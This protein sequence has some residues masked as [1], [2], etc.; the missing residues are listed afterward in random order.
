MFIIKQAFYL[1]QIIFLA[2]SVSAFVPVSVVS[3]FRGRRAMI[4][5]AAIT[6]MM[7]VVAGR[8]IVWRPGDNEIA[9][10]LSLRITTADNYYSGLMPASAG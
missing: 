2:M 6:R 5:M 9:E 7:P 4:Y 8:S 10:K 1:V 3:M